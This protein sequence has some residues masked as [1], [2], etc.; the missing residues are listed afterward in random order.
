MNE[1]TRVATLLVLGEQEAVSILSGI[2]FLLCGAL[3]LSFGVLMDWT[4][5]L[6]F[7]TVAR[8]WVSGDSYRT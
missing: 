6:A 8:V 1:P 3:F 7:V 5:L 4:V 2:C